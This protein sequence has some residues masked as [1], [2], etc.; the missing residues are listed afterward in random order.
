MTAGK[1]FFT[2]DYR[3]AAFK[4]KITAG[5]NLFTPPATR[6]SFGVNEY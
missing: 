1:T 6:A 3:F 4:M 5:T 2:A